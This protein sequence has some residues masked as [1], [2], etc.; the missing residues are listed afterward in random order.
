MSEF[1][2]Q[3]EPIWDGLKIILFSVVFGCPIGGV[4]FALI[5]YFDL[6][7]TS[8]AKSFGDILIVMPLIAL[9]SYLPGIAFALISALGVAIYAAIFRKLKAFNVLL[10]TFIVVVPLIIFLFE[11]DK[12]YSTNSGLEVML[13]MIACCLVAAYFSY[14]LYYNWLSISKLHSVSGGQ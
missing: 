1:T 10:I 3:H 4:F 5:V 13:I 12:R 6:L 2:Q 11:L 14:R 9:F 8:D 7:F